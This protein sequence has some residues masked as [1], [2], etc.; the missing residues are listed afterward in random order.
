M[1]LYRVSISAFLALT[2]ALSSATCLSNSA[3]SSSSF[4]T[5]KLLIRSKEMILRDL[6]EPYIVRPHKV[7]GLTGKEAYSLLET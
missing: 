5:I 4:Y 6:L 1:S 7:G 2:S 3:F